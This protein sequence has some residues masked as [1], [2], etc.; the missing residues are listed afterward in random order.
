MVEKIKGKSKRKSF[1]RKSSKRLKQKIYRTKSKTRKNTKKRNTRKKNTKKKNKRNTKKNNS[2]KKR[3]IGGAD[4]RLVQYF[5]EGR[6]SP[7]GATFTRG[8]NHNS[9]SSYKVLTYS[10]KMNSFLLHKNDGTRV[11]IKYNAFLDNFYYLRLRYP[12]SI[13]DIWEKDKDNCSVSGGILGFREKHHCRHCGMCVSDEHSKGELLL[14]ILIKKG[15]DKFIM[16]NNGSREYKQEIVRVCDLCYSLPRFVVK[17]TKVKLGDEMDISIG[18]GTLVFPQTKH[19]N[20]MVTCKFIDTTTSNEL[21]SQFPE[22]N[23]RPTRMFCGITISH[24]EANTLTGKCVPILNP[25]P[26]LRYTYEHVPVYAF[27]AMEGTRQFGELGSKTY[28]E[29]LYHLDG[30]NGNIERANVL[31]QFLF[32][33]QQPSSYSKV[34][35]VSS[36]EI[37]YLRNNQIFGRRL[38]RAKEIMLQFYGRDFEPDWGVHLTRITRILKCLSMFEG[39]TAAQ[40]FLNKINGVLGSGGRTTSLY[41]RPEGEDRQYHET[42]RYWGQACYDHTFNP[43]IQEAVDL[44]ERNSPPTEVRG[45]D[46]EPDQVEGI[47][48]QSAEDGSGSGSDDEEELFSTCDEQTDCEQ[49]EICACPADKVCPPIKKVCIDSYI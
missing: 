9:G 8:G 38:L 24:L 37:V 21:S 28:D 25:Q 14:D 36:D 22:A 34:P 32:P 41:P 5:S 47:A 15:E 30:N 39:K 3:L 40:D 26:H 16:G 29:I 31:I 7:I 43:F 48:R 44:V 6:W 10:R 18:P 33:I 19:E 27:C 20:N 2:K 46:P 49:D 13:Y 11:T 12:G 35:N 23:L 4:R 42:M 45:L 1:I 17:W